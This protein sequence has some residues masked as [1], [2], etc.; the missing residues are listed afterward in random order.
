MIFKNLL[1][2]RAR[3]VGGKK[4]CILW[5]TLHPHLDRLHQPQVEPSLINAEDK[6]KGTEML[7]LNLWALKGLLEDASTFQRET[8]LRLPGCL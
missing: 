1:H 8:R 2:W 5:K 6:N 7:I 4:Y 3:K